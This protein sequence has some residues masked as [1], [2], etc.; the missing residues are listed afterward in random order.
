MPVT[1]P[2]VY[3]F[4]GLLA[5]AFRGLGKVGGGLSF[6]LGDLLLSLY[7]LHTPDLLLSL[8]HCLWALAILFLTPSGYLA[9]AARF[10]PGTLEYRRIQEEYDHR[11][12]QLAVERLTQVVHIFRELGST[13][14][15]ITATE[16]SRDQ[17]RLNQLFQGICHQ[18]CSS[19]N[20]YH[21][22]WEEEYYKTYRLIFGLLRLAENHSELTKDMV[23]AE[24]RRR[25][26]R[27]QDLVS[28]TNHLLE[29]YRLDQYWQQRLK[30]RSAMVS[31]Q[32]TGVA[33]IIA[34]LSRELKVEVNYREN[35]VTT[36]ERELQEEGIECIHL[37]IFNRADNQLEINLITKGCPANALCSRV[38]RPVAEKVCRCRL[39]LT[40]RQCAL[41][42]GPGECILRLEPAPLFSVTAGG[43]KQGR[44]ASPISGD[45]YAVSELGE[46]RLAL[47][48]SDGMGVGERAYEES[49][50]TI[51]MLE[52]LLTAGFDAELSLRTVNS[53]LLLR[54]EEESF[55]TV[56]LVIFNLY[57]GEA[58]FIKGGSCSS[59]IKR[60]RQVTMVQTPSLPVG[61]VKEIR[62]K[63]FRHPL[64]DGELIVMITD[65]IVGDREEENGWLLKYLKEL[66]SDDPGEVA[67]DILRQAQNQLFLRS[68]DMAVLVARVERED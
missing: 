58:V 55:A 49:A 53:I 66:Q 15:E 26:V 25:C 39:R 27:L 16:Q 46:G 21:N 10:V 8:W 3:A 40:Q 24:L 9:E 29:L 7:I 34:N 6:L 63:T 52:K 41:K 12:R 43:A 13:M 56:D 33:D 64:R 65:G 31:N 54:S 28:G 45:N 51:N 48:L 60:G 1:V 19:C 4:C 5:G 35:L 2:G 59:L 62:L 23:S 14:E 44:N 47:I 68:D 61:I 17:E 67:R 30:E 42:D 20:L 50:A 11:V 38:I 37:N 36:L 57:R 22:C 32:L 18:V